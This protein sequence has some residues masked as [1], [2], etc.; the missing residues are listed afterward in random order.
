[1]TTIRG[2]LDQ[3]IERAV[4]SRKTTPPERVSKALRSVRLGRIGKVDLLHLIDE[5]GGMTKEDP[6]KGFAALEKAQA[7]AQFGR[8]LQ[9]L[10][11]AWTLS[12]PQWTSQIAHFCTRVAERVNKAL[13]CEQGNFVVLSKWW[14]ELLKEVDSTSNDF[15]LQGGN[16]PPASAPNFKWIEDQSALYNYELTA[17]FCK[18]QA[19]HAGRE[20]ARE[21]VE[22]NAARPATGSETPKSDANTQ[23]LQNEIANLKRQL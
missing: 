4:T 10:Q 22:F 9:R 14:R 16:G 20:G 23:R 7:Q 8:A 5:D 1:M 21:A 6:L 19:L 15:A 13:N 18:L 17:E 3:R 11:L 2:A 12:K